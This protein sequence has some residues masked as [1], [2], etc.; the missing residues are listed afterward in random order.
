GPTALE[1]PGD[2]L[3]SEHAVF[4]EGAKTTADEVDAILIDCIFDPAVEALQKHLDIPVFG[5]LRTSLA[6][7]L[8]VSPN[9]AIVGRGS[10]HGEMFADIVARYGYRD[11]LAAIRTLDL[12]YAKGR[13]AAHFDVAMRQ[14]LKQVVE[15]DHAR[16]VVLGSTTMALTDEVAAVAGDVPLFLTGMVTLGIM[17]SLWRDGLL[18]TAMGRTAASG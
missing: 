17:E 18:R 6:L 16:A 11:R 14:R 10:Q 12:T 2:M 7:V 5:P 15:E 3:F 9:F 13:Q 8:M 1:T 4:Q